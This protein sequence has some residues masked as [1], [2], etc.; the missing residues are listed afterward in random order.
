MEGVVTAYT[1]STLT[2][3]MDLNSGTGTHADWNI[4]LAGQR[5][6]TGANGAD[7][8]TGATGSTGATGATGAAGAGVRAFIGF[9]E[10]VCAIVRGSNRR[11]TPTVS[12]S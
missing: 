4:N 12:I 10:D 6:A 2:A 3:T 7:G 5:G 8:A 9:L 1:G 11:I